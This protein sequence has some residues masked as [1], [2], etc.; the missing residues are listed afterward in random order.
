MWDLTSMGH[1][2]KSGRLPLTSKNRFSFKNGFSKTLQDTAASRYARRAAESQATLAWRIQAPTRDWP[3]GRIRC[4][5]SLRRPSHPLQNSLTFHVF[6]EFVERMIRN[7]PSRLNGLFQRPLS[8]LFTSNGRPK[9]YNTTPS[10]DH[11]R[12]QHE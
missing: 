3:R 10:H 4:H 11:W 6:A 2:T 5:E 9:L 8:S 7:L 1:S 12:D